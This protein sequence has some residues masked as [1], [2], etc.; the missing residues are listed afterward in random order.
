[1]SAAVALQLAFIGFLVLLRL[2]EKYL[3][4]GTPKFDAKERRDYRLPY[5]RGRD[6]AMLKDLTP[7]GERRRKTADE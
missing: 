4:E 3:D 1:M 2:L 5:D 7:V 6:R